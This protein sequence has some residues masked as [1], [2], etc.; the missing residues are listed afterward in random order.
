[1]KKIFP[2]LLLMAV[3]SACQGPMGPEGPPGDS[4]QWAVRTITV[5]TNE[6]MLSG[7]P[8][9][10]G[11]YYYADKS[12]PELTAFVFNEGAVIGYIRTGDNVKNIL[13]YVLHKGEVGATGEYLW[14]QTYDFDF[15][16]GA[17]RFY[18]TFSDFMTGS[19]RPGT[20]TYDI[21]LIW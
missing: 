6:W 20:E 16:P 7:R 5:H 1:M 18:V 10:L 17:V 9:E 14:T 21:V 19:A 3:F 4:T 13:P 2:I 8:N 15:S 11:S 12:I